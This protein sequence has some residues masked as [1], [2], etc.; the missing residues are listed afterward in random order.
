MASKKKEQP[1]QRG[2]GS[3]TFDV[4]EGFIPSRPAGSRVPTGE[5]KANDRQVAGT[6]YKNHKIEPW[7]ITALNGLDVF[8]HEICTYVMRYKDKG[9]VAD[10]EKAK[11]WLEKYIEV[12]NAGYGT[13]EGLNPSYVVDQLRKQSHEIP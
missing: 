2:I 13:P 1:T 3:Q 4:H 7:D 11:H 10:L 9:G 5:P 12:V 6:H 8:Q